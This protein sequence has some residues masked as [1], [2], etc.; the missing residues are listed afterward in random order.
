MFGDGRI[1]VRVLNGNGPGPVAFFGGE[2]DGDCES[3]AAAGDAAMAK[4]ARLARRVA[5]DVSLELMHF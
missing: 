4:Q 1:N 5:N 3:E 2:G